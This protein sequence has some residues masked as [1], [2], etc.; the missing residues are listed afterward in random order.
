MT[1]LKVLNQKLP[2]GLEDGGVEFYVLDTGEI[3]CLIDGGAKS[4]DEIPKDILDLIA[5]DLARNPEAIKA[6]RDWNIYDSDEMLKQYIFCRFGGFDN[7]PDITPDRKIIYTEYFDCGKRGKCKYEGKIC[8]TIKVG[9]DHQGNNINLTKR[10]LEVLKLVAQGKIDKEIA[11]ILDM[12]EE[13]VRSHNQNI[14]QKGNF[15]R[16]PDMIAF[17]IEKNLV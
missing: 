6:I 12:S 15:N 3:K 10:E 2:A 11:S 7:E 1:C 13:T 9:E 8:A 16:K 17:A 4:W 5:E 14:R